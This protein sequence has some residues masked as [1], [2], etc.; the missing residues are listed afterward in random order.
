M[1]IRFSTLRSLFLQILRRVRLS[2]RCISRRSSRPNQSSKFLFGQI[3]IRWLL[4]TLEEERCACQIL[5]DTMFNIKIR[6]SQIPS[7]RRNM[8]IRQ[9]STQELCVCN[10]LSGQILSTVS[11]VVLGSKKICPILVSIFLSLSQR[12]QT[13]TQQPLSNYWGAFLYN[14]IFWSKGLMMSLH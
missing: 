5:L 9:E 11:T 3:L 8:F 12:P 7:L 10:L 14:Q 13:R 6:S 2:S 1:L 4:I